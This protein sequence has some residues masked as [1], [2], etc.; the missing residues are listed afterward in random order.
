[1]SLD[2][3]RQVCP[4]VFS[5]HAHPDRSER[6]R[7][8]PTIEPLTKLLE[9]GWGV[10]EASQ[11]KSTKDKEREAFT[12]HMLRLRKMADFNPI[13]VV[14]EGIPE[15][16][17]INA[18]D[19]TSK[20]YMKGGYFT[21]VC[22]NGMMVGK[23]YASFT[24][25]HTVGPQ[26]AQEVLEAGERIVT[27][28]FPRL[29]QRVAEFKAIVL[30]ADK[31]YRLANKAMSLR[32][33]GGGMMPFTAAELLAPQ[34]AEQAEPTLWNILNR[35]QEGTIYGGMSV[36]SAFFGRASRVRP[37]E[38]VSAVA[39]INAGIWDEAEAIANEVA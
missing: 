38:R 35:V 17:M 10:Y 5:E 13:A 39:H 19:G 8:V 9:N 37:V 3:I 23:D 28:N 21:F 20:Y 15:V 18:H 1:L 27:E 31:Q 7:Y 4:A 26:T 30:D 34:H 32:Y 14:G 36:R 29:I 16:I 6:Y 2:A 11:Q 24:I 33:P 25:K 22:S 12:K